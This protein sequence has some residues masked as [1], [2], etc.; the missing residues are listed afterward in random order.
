[1]LPALYQD[2]D[3]TARW[4]SGFDTVLA[5]VLTT[6]DC[7]GA[8]LDPSLAPEDFLTWLG[9]WVG[10]A[11]DPDADLLT[12]RRLVADAVELF[13]QRG[14]V[15]GIVGVLEASL[16]VTCEVIEGGAVRAS[17]V[18]A[19]PLPGDPAGAFIVRLRLRDPAGIPSPELRRRAILLVEATRPAHLPAAVEF[20]DGAGRPIAADDGGQDHS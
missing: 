17:T 9:S 3:F 4:L 8:Y 5:P 14:T 15:R 6:L 16:P 11:L 18:P 10:V 1:M 12:R 20:V 13:G 19:G 2:D 7:F